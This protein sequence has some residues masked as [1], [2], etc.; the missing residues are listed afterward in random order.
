MNLQD[1]IQ[2]TEQALRHT[3]EASRTGVDDSTGKGTTTEFIVEKHLLVP[4]LPTGFR[5]Q[6]GAVVEAEAPSVQSPAIDRIVYEP[7]VSPPLVYGEAHSVFPIESVAG[8]VEITMNLDA[9]KLATDLG[10]IAVVRAMK[11]RRFTTPMAGTTT[12]VGR[13]MKDD[14]LSPR[15]FIIGLPKNPKWKPGTIAKAVRERQ[16]ALGRPTHLHGLYVIGIGYFETLAVE[17]GEPTYRIQ[18][19]LGNDRLFRFTNSFRQAFQRWPPLPPLWAADLDGYLEG[20]ATI[21]E[22]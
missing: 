16:M 17:K 6:K 15:S 4:Y 1:S 21:Y 12:K 7:H 8:V 9:D 18:Q 13:V 3:L 11:R 20:E 14:F 10:R 19:W 5:C 2:K 22:D